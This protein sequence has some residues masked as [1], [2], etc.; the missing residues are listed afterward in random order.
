MVRAPFRRAGSALTETRGAFSQGSVRLLPGE[1]GELNHPDDHPPDK[2]IGQAEAETNFHGVETQLFANGDRLPK[3][4]GAAFP[5]NTPSA[6]P[7]APKPNAAPITV[8]NALAYSASPLRCGP[9]SPIHRLIKRASTVPRW[10]IGAQQALSRNLLCDWAHR[11]T[12]CAVI[13]DASD[14]ANGL[15][16]WPLRIKEK[17]QRYDATDV[18][19]EVSCRRDDKRR[20]IGPP[21]QNASAAALQ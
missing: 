6:A 16:D 14:P 8:A 4:P 10:N 13:R 11:C 21:P 15:A 9:R 17:L 7:A 3:N 1:D 19:I 18:A 12:G 20:G 5:R 2:A